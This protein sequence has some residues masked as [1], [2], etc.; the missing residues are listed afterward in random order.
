MHY[1]NTRVPDT[2]TQFD[3]NYSRCLGRR[4]CYNMAWNAVEATFY[5]DH[6][7]P[8]DNRDNCDRD[9]YCTYCRGT[10]FEEA[11]LKLHS[12][13]GKALEREAYKPEGF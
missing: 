13:Q 3:T 12:T 8:H 7:I 2:R 4:R 10:K 9:D 11:P 5:Y 6:K 1:R